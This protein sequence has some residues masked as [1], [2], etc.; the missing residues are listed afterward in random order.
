LARELADD[1]GV[2]LLNYR[3]RDSA[4]DGRSKLGREIIATGLAAH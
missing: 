1:L 4:L 2:A 3:A